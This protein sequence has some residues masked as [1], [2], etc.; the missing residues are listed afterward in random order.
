MAFARL[1]TPAEAQVFSVGARVSQNTDV[2]D[3]TLGVGAQAVVSLP[4]VGLGFSI[5]GDLFFPDCDDCAFRDLGINLRW[6]FPVPALDPYIGAG[7]TVQRFDGGSGA[8]EDLGLNLLAG[9]GFSRIFAEVKLQI[10]QDFD[11]QIV[12]TGG[13]SLPLL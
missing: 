10:M 1:A 4:V 6:G 11:R 5:S 12:V 8:E 2:E 13:L 9:M 7:L 3:G